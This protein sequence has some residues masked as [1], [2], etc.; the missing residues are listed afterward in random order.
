M[1]RNRLTF[2]L[3]V[4]VVVSGCSG[5]VSA[6]PQAE[7]VGGAAQPSEPSLPLGE[8]PPGPCEIEQPY[9]VPVDGGRA[10]VDVLPVFEDYPGLDGMHY[11]DRTG[12]Y[13][14]QEG[15]AIGEEDAHRIEY[16][17]DQVL[18]IVQA[19]QEGM[20]LPADLVGEVVAN[21]VDREANGARYCTEAETLDV[22]FIGETLIDYSEDPGPS[23]DDAA[24]DRSP[25]A[26]AVWEL[27]APDGT[28]TAVDDA[29]TL[30]PAYSTE[31][32]SKR[33]SP[34]TS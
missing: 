27:T 31:R 29:P 21:P 19:T 10:V 25:T 12:D 5:P 22:V 4:V 24:L 23:G 7:T 28:L 20:Q 15:V 2:A 30:D 17:D 32:A 11:D 3:S 13:M 14:D 26:V 16:T 9:A 6:P 18:L 8:F 33:S 34:R 1:L